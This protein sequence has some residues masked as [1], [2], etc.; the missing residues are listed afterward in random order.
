M[1][2][3]RFIIAAHKKGISSECVFEAFFDPVYYSLKRFDFLFLNR[4]TVGI[5]GGKITH[6]YICHTILTFLAPPS[7]CHLPLTLPHYCDN[8]NMLSGRK[9]NHCWIR[10]LTDIPKFSFL[11]DLFSSEAPSNSST[12]ADSFGTSILSRRCSKK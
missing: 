2:L 10:I 3:I 1:I 6:C 5:W 9:M 11:G 7:K 12:M 8:Q 4:G